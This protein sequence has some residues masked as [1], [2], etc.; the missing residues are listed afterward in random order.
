MYQCK[1]CNSFFDNPKLYTETHSF[2]SLPYEKWTGCPSCSGAYREIIECDE[3]GE[4]KIGEYIKTNR[5]IC[6]CE[7]CYSVRNTDND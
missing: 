1:D 2:I 6:I 3:C 5:G 7:S 4:Y